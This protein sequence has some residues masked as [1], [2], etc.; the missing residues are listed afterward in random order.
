MVFKIKCFRRRG[1]NQYTM[2]SDLFP[3]QNVEAVKSVLLRVNSKQQ[4]NA[5][6]EIK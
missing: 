1:N 2:K 4:L 3:V 6:D 5:N